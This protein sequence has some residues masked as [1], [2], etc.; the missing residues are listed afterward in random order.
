MTISDADF[1]G[2][3]SHARDAQAKAERDRET[4]IWQGAVRS[5]AAYYSDA[6]TKVVTDTERGVRQYGEVS[7]DPWG[8]KESFGYAAGNAMTGDNHG[9]YD[10]D[11]DHSVEDADN[12]S[13]SETVAQLPPPSGPTVGRA[14]IT[15][16]R[17][18]A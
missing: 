2:L 13:V 10:R 7:E 17:R 5:S 16:R 9:G 4:A 1:A 14:M 15:D 3:G 8:I 6:S 18:F 11:G 12:H